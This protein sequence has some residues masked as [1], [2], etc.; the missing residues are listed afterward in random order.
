MQKENWIAI[1]PAVYLDD[2]ECALLDK[3]Q[4]RLS[5]GDQEFLQF[6]IVIG[7]VA[8]AVAHLRNVRLKP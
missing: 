2:V 7:K 6:M 5:L 4:K 1:T 3:V 8:P